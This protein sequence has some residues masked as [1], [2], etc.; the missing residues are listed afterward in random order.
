M[1]A[2]PSPHLTLS[3]ELFD[4]LPEP[5]RAYIRSLEVIV[6]SLGSTANS[7]KATSQ[8]H[9]VLIEK[10]QDQINELE[11]RL[12]KDSARGRST[13]STVRPRRNI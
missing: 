6:S 1:D 10:L 11:G 3:S 4:S 8:E 9:Q 12:S 2:N 7:L 5:V 13:R